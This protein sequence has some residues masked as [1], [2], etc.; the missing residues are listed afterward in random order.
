MAARVKQLWKGVFN[1]RGE[2]PI[3]RRYAYTREQAWLL[4]CRYL[5]KRHGVDPAWVMGMFKP[6]SDNHSIEL[7][8]EVV[9]VDS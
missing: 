3:V 1:Y 2:M 8:V 6:G 7:E 4:M 5:A 9:E